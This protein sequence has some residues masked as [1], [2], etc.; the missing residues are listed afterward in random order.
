MFITVSKSDPVRKVLHRV[1]ILFCTLV[2][3]TCASAPVAQ[4]EDLDFDWEAIENAL[5][6]D[7][8]SGWVH[9]AAHDL[10]TYVFTF[11]DPDDFFKHVEMSLLPFSQDAKDVM[12]KLG[13]HDAV[14][15]KGMF[16]Q[17]PSLQRHI[18]VTAIEVTKPHETKIQARPYEREAKMPYDLLD[19]TEVTVLVHATVEEGKILVVEYK[20]AIVPV[21]V[22]DNSFTKDL[23][24]GDV[25]RLKYK[26]I[27]S[28]R[29][30]THITLDIDAK[31]PVSVLR[32]ITKRHG[33]RATLEG[34][35]VLFPKSPQIVF[36]IFAL[37]SIDEDGIK[38]NFTLVNFDDQD[39]FKAIR[40][41]L[42]GAWSSYP[43]NVTSGRNYFVN[44]GVNLKVSGT[45]NV[46]SKSQANPQLL[47]D[48]LDDIVINKKD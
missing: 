2:T 44:T 31:E 20:D 29:L 8:L 38:I 24:R 32:S 15:I 37:Q 22:K 1:A 25:I 19:K 10:D 28:P 34:L 27:E 36:D 26:Q 11:R 4:A 35:L 30:P 33:E 13:R 42:A 16:L 6:G 39:L 7:G 45:W 14:V 47:I 41:K 21:F 5:K 48:S 17:N 46:V 40:E 3:L 18:G 23:F 43:D 12:G 9:G